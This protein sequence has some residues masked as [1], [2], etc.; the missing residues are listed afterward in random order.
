MRKL[1][2]LFSK[3]Q[4]KI[5][6][7]WAAFVF[8]GKL[9]IKFPYDR[10]N[11]G[12][13]DDNMLPF[14]EAIGEP[15]SIFH[16]KNASIHTAQSIWKWFLNNVVL[17]LPWPSVSFDLNPMENVEMLSCTTGEKSTKLHSEAWYT[18][19]LILF[20]HYLKNMLRKMIT[21]VNF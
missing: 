5:A 11:A 13:L 9:D 15:Y 6:S 2:K 8:D 17:V 1:P 4:Q 16:L 19:C 7:L 10:K 14:S 21:K 20:S 18:L 12:L 3:R